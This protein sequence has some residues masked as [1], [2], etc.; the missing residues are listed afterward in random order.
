MSKPETPVRHSTLER[1]GELET[2][3]P[4]KRGIAISIRESAMPTR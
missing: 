1:V 2:K 4:R 3:I